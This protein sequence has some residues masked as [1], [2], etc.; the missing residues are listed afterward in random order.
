MRRT[1]PLRRLALTLAVGALSLSVGVTLAGSAAAFDGTCTGTT[2]TGSGTHTFNGTNV[3]LP[4]ATLYFVDSFLPANAQRPHLTSSRVTP[5]P[6]CTRATISAPTV[7]PWPASTGDPNA[8]PSGVPAGQGVF[9][10]GWT[11]NVPAG[12]KRVGAMKASW[13]L[14]WTEPDDTTTPDVRPP[15]ITHDF[16]VRILTPPNVSPAGTLAVSVI[17]S[18]DGPAASPAIATRAAGALVFRS[19]AL[20]PIAEAPA[21]CTKEKAEASCGVRQLRLHAEQSFIFMVRV[22]RKNPFTLSAKI[23]LAGCYVEESA[24]L[25]NQAYENLTT[26]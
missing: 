15:K 6:P 2:C 21:G 24:C 16:V 10:I 7:D 17:V 26:R 20:Y 5:S 9:R 12:S 3:C 14:A 8:R 22:A 25:N 4:G 19:S 23:N 18:N 13:A 11:V 1:T